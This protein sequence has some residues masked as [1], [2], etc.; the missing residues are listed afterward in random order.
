VL[1]SSGGTDYNV[2]KG[3]PIPTGSSLELIDSGSK[4]VIQTGDVV[5]AF[6]DTASAIDVLISFV[7]TISS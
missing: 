2:I 5:K 1:I 7:D 4:I 6:S 3:A